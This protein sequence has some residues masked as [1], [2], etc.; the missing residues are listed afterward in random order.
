MLNRRYPIAHQSKMLW[1]KEASGTSYADIFEEFNNTASAELVSAILAP[2]RKMM[3]VQRIHKSNKISTELREKGNEMFAKRKWRFAMECYSEICGRYDPDD[4]QHVQFIVRSIVLAVNAFTS[5][6][7]LIEFVESATKEKN[8]KR[9]PHSTTDMKSKYRMFLKQN[10][11]MTEEEEKQWFSIAY[12]VFIDICATIPTFDTKFDTKDKKRFLMHL[13][14]MH[15]Y[16]INCNLFQNKRK[17]GIY[18]LQGHFSHFCAHNLV[19]YFYENKSVCITSRRIKKGDQLFVTHNADLWDQPRDMRQ[20]FYLE[21]FG[22]QCECE[23]CENPSWPV[24]S[25]QIQSE[26]DFQFLSKEMKVLDNLDDF[27]EFKKC[28]MLEQKCLN[29][30]RKYQDSQWCTELDIVSHWLSEIHQVMY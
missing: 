19:R 13:C 30:L 17:E 11:W 16:I 4:D 18:L 28:S 26:Q 21:R 10:Q 22:F 23:K 1:K 24:S 9:V 3:G 29:I 25:K 12:A 14:L 15:T 20:S 5:Y 7:N 6:E 27:I 2:L 8:D